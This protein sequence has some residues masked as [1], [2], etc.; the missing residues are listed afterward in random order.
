MAGA[1]LVFGGARAEPAGEMAPLAEFGGRVEI[2]SLLAEEAL[3]VGRA[4][5]AL[6]AAFS[7]ESVRP[8]VEVPCRA[9]ARLCHC[10]PVIPEPALVVVA[11]SALGL[12][13]ST[14][15]FAGVVTTNAVLLADFACVIS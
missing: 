1:A 7:A 8:V 6:I 13:S 3:V 11:G 4:G 9:R 12:E 2:V 14:A 10:N 15:G 5:L